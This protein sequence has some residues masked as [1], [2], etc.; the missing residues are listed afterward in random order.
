MV[1]ASFAIAFA[2]SAILL[3]R[4]HEAPPSFVALNAIRNF[5]LIEMARSGEHPIS[6]MS[7][8]EIDN[9]WNELTSTNDPWGNQYVTVHREDAGVFGSRSSSHIYARGED[10]VSH[11]NGGDADDINSWSPKM[12]QFYQRRQKKRAL[13]L[14]AAYSLVLTIP[15]YAVSARAANWL[16]GCR[17]CD[18]PDDARESPS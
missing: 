2:T 5:R 12:N 17:M 4:P 8:A 13:A 3:P 6:G 9:A 18:E 10:G 7:A 16:F 1:V 14:W 11:S 15:L